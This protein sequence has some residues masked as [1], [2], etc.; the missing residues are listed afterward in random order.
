MSA[1]LK[2]TAM[3]KSRTVPAARIVAFSLAT[4]I[5]VLSVV[6]PSLRPESSLPHDLEH[7][8]IYFATGLAFAVGYQIR[9]SLLALLLVIFC[10]AVEITQLFIPGRH[11]RLSDFVV[12][13]LAV[14]FGAMAASLFARFAPWFE[15]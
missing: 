8:I 9:V 2:H 13:A 1:L 11:A 5:V 10:A 6:P 14:T 7:F 4:T 15:R 3:I 12:D